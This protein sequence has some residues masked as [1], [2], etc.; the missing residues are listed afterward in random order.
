MIDTNIHSSSGTRIVSE[1]HADS[2]HKH[3]RNNSMSSV[4]SVMRRYENFDLF[5]I[6][7]DGIMFS[8]KIHLV[9]GR[10]FC[11]FLCFYIK[12][13]S[14]LPATHIEIHLFSYKIRQ[15]CILFLFNMT[16]CNISVISYIK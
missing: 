2:L 6:S 11:L 16:G 7:K 15:I 8:Y 14:D 1:Y 5:Q 12:K 13:L 4:V 3:M 10:F 9:C